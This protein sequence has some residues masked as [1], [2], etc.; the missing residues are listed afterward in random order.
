MY[1]RILSRISG[2]GITDASGFGELYPCGELIRGEK[3]GMDDDVLSTL[4]D[5]VWVLKDALP[6]RSFDQTNTSPMLNH[7]HVPVAPTEDSVWYTVA[8]SHI[9]HTLEFAAGT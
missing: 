2:G 5:I 1:S 8:G 6:R 4:A 7:N 9:H 3:E